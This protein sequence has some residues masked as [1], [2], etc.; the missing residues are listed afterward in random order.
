MK[1]MLKFTTLFAISFAAFG[2]AAAGSVGDGKLDACDSALLQHVRDPLARILD[3]LTPSE[4][5]L[6]E[7]DNETNINP[8]AIVN[9]NPVQVNMMLMSEPVVPTPTMS[10]ATE[11][12][13]SGAD[14]F[15]KGDAIVD[16]AGH[17]PNIRPVEKCTPVGQ[18]CDVEACK[19][20]RAILCY[21]G[22]DNKCHWNT[23]DPSANSAACN[24]CYCV[25]A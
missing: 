25:R 22:A 10:S 15:I 9:N 8:Y 21:L 16:E 13:T 1:A 18:G 19:A 24:W 12:T 6:T 20:T 3:H 23:L 7:L 11:T 14:G 5:L 17:E 2:V 4:R